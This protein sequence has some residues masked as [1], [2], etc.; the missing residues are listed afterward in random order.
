MKKQKFETVL[1]ITVLL[2][3]AANIAAKLAGYLRA[4]WWYVLSPLLFFFS[5]IGLLTVI[6][7]LFIK[8]EESHA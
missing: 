6:T 1:F 5:T 7:I 2:W 3:Q 8:E 4:D